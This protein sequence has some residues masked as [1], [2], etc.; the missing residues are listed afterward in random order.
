ML[1]PRAQQ[2]GQSIDKPMFPAPRWT[3]FRRCEPMVTCCRLMLCQAFRSCVVLFA[4][5]QRRSSSEGAECAWS[6][7]VWPMSRMDMDLM[8]AGRRI[9]TAK[10]DSRP[11]SPKEGNID[12]SPD[13]QMPLSSSHYAQ[14]TLSKPDRAG[15]IAT[16]REASM[17]SD[18]KISK[19]AHCVSVATRD[20][21]RKHWEEAKDILFEVISPLSLGSI[22]AGTP[23]RCQEGRTRARPKVG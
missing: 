13:E 21:D 4:E 10:K 2:D 18:D 23:A 9:R 19:E 7:D 17:S 14:Y 22:P 12:E 20:F 5:R 11:G 3:A 6:D 15:R 1:E 16:G 8:A